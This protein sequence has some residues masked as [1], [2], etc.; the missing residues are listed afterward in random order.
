MIVGI[1]GILECIA[2]IMGITRYHGA[3]I[4]QNN[5]NDERLNF[6]GLLKNIPTVSR[7]IGLVVLREETKPSIFL[8]Y[9]RTS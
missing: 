4:L 8:Q 5:N 9:Q 7:P 2:A 6:S 3:T 1:C